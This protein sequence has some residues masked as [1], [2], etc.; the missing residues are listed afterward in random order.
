[1]IIETARVKDNWSCD[2][3]NVSNLISFDRLVKTYKVI[4]KL[5]PESLWDKYELRSVHSKYEPRNCQDLQIIGPN[6]LEP[7]TLEAKPINSEKLSQCKN[8]RGAE[9]PK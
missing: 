6:T 2:W 9:P 4:N 5:S 8:S 1:M 7:N 3:L